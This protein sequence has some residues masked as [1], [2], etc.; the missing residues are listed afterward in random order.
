M[1]KPMPLSDLIIGTIFWGGLIT[2]LIFN[3]PIII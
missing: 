1:K 3:P 2:F